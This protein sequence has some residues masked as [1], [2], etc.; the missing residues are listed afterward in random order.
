MIKLK[1]YNHA[2]ENLKQEKIEQR[3]KDHK[4]LQKAKEMEQKLG[5]KPKIL[6]AGASGNFLLKIKK[7]ERQMQICPRCNKQRPKSDFIGK[8][9]E[10]TKKCNPCREYT[11]KY[12]ENNKH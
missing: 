3:K 1:P 2:H 8:R 9:K 10:I 7:E 5:I 4:A 11:K 12:K 6:P